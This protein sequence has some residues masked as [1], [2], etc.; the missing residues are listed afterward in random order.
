MQDA[1]QLQAIISAL[2]TTKS[3]HTIKEINKSLVCYN[4]AHIIKL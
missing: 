4:N 1:T 3:T 2:K